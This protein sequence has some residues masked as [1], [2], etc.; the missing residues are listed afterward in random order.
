MQKQILY[1]LSLIAKS[2]FYI[3]YFG[4]SI[5]YISFVRNF[6][7]FLVLAIYLY[8]LSYMV[9]GDWF[10][11]YFELPGNGF[12]ELLLLCIFLFGRF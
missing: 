2:Y 3:G 5:D 1:C 7:N 11:E 12:L 4:Y 10:L 9:I 8:N 6:V